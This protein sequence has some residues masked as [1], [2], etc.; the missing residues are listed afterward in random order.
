MH[1]FIKT[2]EFLWNHFNTEDGRENNIF[3]ILCFTISRKV[4]RNE[5]QNKIC[6]VWRRCCDR[7]ECVESG[8]RSFMLEISHWMMLRGLVDQLKS[9]IK[10]R[11]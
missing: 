3:D 2:G 10:S 9:M 11:H 6:I 4:K 1:F 5:V 7:F 8:L